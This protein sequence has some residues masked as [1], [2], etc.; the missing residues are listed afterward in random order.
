M[1]RRCR[2]ACALRGHLCKGIRA[3][4]RADDHRVRCLSLSWRVRALRKAREEGER[5]GTSPSVSCLC[6]MASMSRSLYSSDATC[7]TQH[8]TATY[9]MQRACS[10]R[11]SNPP[12][13]HSNAAYHIRHKMYGA[14]CNISVARSR[15]AHVAASARS[16]RVR[17][18]LP[19]CTWAH[20]P[21]IPAW[22]IPRV[23]S[24]KTAKHTS[25]PPPVANA[26]VCCMMHSACC[27]F[28]CAR[29]SGRG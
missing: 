9:H 27:L 3:P 17:P 11:T 16:Q 21:A 26:V 22:L 10:G 6:N 5:R 20:S 25:H 23:L 24:H 12:P 1:A 28:R 2:A 29:T 15:Q 13:T 8:T 19:S 18:A 7:T 14:A 4:L